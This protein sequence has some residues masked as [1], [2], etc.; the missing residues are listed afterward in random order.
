[1]N[2]PLS[3]GSTPRIHEKRV[4]KKRSNRSKP[5]TNFTYTQDR[6]EDTPPT[7]RKQVTEHTALQI[8][9][10]LRDISYSFYIVFLVG[11]GIF[12]LEVPLLAAI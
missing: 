10:S 12:D 8:K 7:I 5:I 9:G 3:T 6:N 11:L 1:M 4:T 2:L